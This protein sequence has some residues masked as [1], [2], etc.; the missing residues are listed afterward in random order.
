MRNSVKVVIGAVLAGTGGL[1][2]W[3]QTQP[4]PEPEPVAGTVAESAAEPATEPATETAVAKAPNLA[5]EPEP[6]PAPVAAPEFDVVRVSPDGQA[7]IAGR[8]APDQTVEILLDG[9]VIGT[10]EA[11]ATGA[12]AT[13]LEVAPSGEPRELTLRTALADAPEAVVVLAPTVEAGVDEAA[14]EAAAA[15]QAAAEAAAAESAAA[16]TAVAEAAAAEAAAVE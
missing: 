13:V 12:F 9:T 16:E 3:W 4:V 2:V 8:A 6:E 5:P 1:L 11:D 14:A 7:V 10:V 15:E